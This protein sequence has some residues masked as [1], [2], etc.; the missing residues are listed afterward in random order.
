MEIS[1]WYNINFN[2]VFATIFFTWHNIW[3]TELTWQVQKKICDLI[4]INW[5]TARQIYFWIW[6]SSRKLL[7]KL[8]SGGDCIPHEIRLNDQVD[9]LLTFLF[10]VCGKL[11][12]YHGLVTPH[13][14]MKFDC[15]WFRI[16]ACYLC[17]T[18]PLNQWRNAENGLKYVV[19]E[20]RPTK[21]WPFCPGLNVFIKMLFNICG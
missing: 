12:T 17:G 14:A 15:H 6:I 18:K 11:L 9:W 1:F 21:W 4:A 8:T 20:G 19:N 16:M 2:K 7:V 10:F 3:A 13:G 5:N